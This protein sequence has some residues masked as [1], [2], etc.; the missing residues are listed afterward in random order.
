[1]A[2]PVPITPAPTA[3][4]AQLAQGRRGDGKAA[5]FFLSPSLL[6]LLAFT[7]FPI[8]AS[9]LLSFYN[10]PVIGRHT[11]I[12]LKNYQTLLANDAF[13][14][15]ILNTLLFVVLYVPLNIVISLGLAVWISPRI[16][17]RG[18]YRTLFFIPAVTPVVANAAIFSLILSPN[19][20]VDAASQSW[21]DKQAPN[22]LGSTTWAMAAVVM[23]SIWQGFGYNM[24]VFSAAL[25][26]VPSSLTEQA[27][28]DG[29]STTARFFRIV[30]PLLTPSI[31]FAVVL[32]LIS[33]FQVF[34]Q[35]YV[36]TGGGPGNTTTTMV[37]YLYEQGFRFFKL[38]LA[39]AVAWVLFL[40]ILVITVFQF[41]GQKRWVNY[42][43]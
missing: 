16:K 11:F 36:L 4:A 12:G 35:A 2:I 43:Q 9:M 10:W 29:A 41:I 1:M 25:D 7:S 19:G 23:L 39:S 21:F 33:S 24:L 30:L 17:G 34:T 8:V 20:L 5:T 6:G 31:F 22:F 13:R 42:D 3:S 37:L 18:F 38:G 32:T 15:A 40:I 14:T 27:A 26:A 28:I